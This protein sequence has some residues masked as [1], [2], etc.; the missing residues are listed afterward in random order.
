MLEA[1]FFSISNYTLIIGEEQEASW[2]VN[3]S[4]LTSSHQGID[5]SYF[6]FVWEEGR[7]R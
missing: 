3:I 6:Y 1:E 7:E 2:P 5:L 4:S